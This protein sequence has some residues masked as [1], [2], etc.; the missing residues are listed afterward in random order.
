VFLVFVGVVLAS[1]VLKMVF[2]DGSTAI[3]A[4]FFLKKWITF[5]PSLKNKIE[6]F[7]ENHFFR[8]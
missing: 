6:V 7:L 5:C 1:S 3:V 8:V 2:R 4:S